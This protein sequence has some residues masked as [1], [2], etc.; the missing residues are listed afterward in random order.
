VGSYTGERPSHSVKN[1]Q[2]SLELYTADRGMAMGTPIGTGSM[3]ADCTVMLGFVIA[4]YF[5]P[6]VESPRATGAV[7]ELTAA[8]KEIGVASFLKRCKSYPPKFTGG[9][10]TELTSFAYSTGRKVA[11]GVFTEDWAMARMLEIEWVATYMEEEPYTVE[12]NIRRGFRD[13]AGSPWD[14]AEV[15]GFFLDAA[16]FGEGELPAG[17]SLDPVKRRADQIA[18]N[19]RL[20][21]GSDEHNVSEILTLEE[22]LSRFVYITEMESVQD[23]QRPR[24]IV[25]F[26]AWTREHCASKTERVVEGQWGPGGVAKTKVYPTSKL[27]MEASG[28]KKAPSVTFRPGALILTEDPDGNESANTWRP[29]DRKV[30]ATSCDLFLSHIDYLFGADAPRFL[31]WLAHIEQN[32]GVLPHSGWVHVS[33]SQGTGRNWLASV[34]CRLWRGYVAPS[35]DLAGT[36]NS[37]FNGRLSHKLL[38]VVDEIDEGGSEAKWGNAE[39]LKSLVTAEARAINSEVW[40]PAP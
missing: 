39:A 11:A 30:S 21:E 28:R 5:Q 27:W 35:F 2:L 23:L 16:G 32:P 3:D 40:S 25:S 36:L 24:S 4:C 1:D 14:G 26:N 10:N 38:A 22:M 15:E 29:I 33:P 7:G 13:S 31:D 20:G 37:G 18:E 17:A 6:R 19:I 12:S 34:L 8:Q 9:W